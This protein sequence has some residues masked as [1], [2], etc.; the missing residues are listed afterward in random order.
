MICPYRSFLATWSIH[1]LPTPAI[2]CSSSLK[3]P[4]LSLKT[5]VE[6]RK[7]ADSQTAQQHWPS[8]KPARRVLT[9]MVSVS[10]R[11]SSHSQLQVILFCHFLGGILSKVVVYL[12]IRLK[13]SK[14]ISILSILCKIE[15]ISIFRTIHSKIQQTSVKTSYICRTSGKSVTSANYMAEFSAFNRF[16]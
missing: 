2:P 5:Q 3:C 12:C 9:L 13:R 6:Q 11:K 15:T 10:Q 1:S 16:F 8:P 14:I 7:A 4:S